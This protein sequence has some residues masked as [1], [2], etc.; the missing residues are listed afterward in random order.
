M[1]SNTDIKDVYNYVSVKEKILDHEM[2]TDEEKKREVSFRDKMSK[3]KAYC[4]DKEPVLVITTASI[5]LV[6]SMVCLGWFAAHHVLKR[7]G[8]WGEWTSWSTC[9]HNC[10]KYRFRGC[11]QPYPANGGKDC[12]GYSS[13][14]LACNLGKCRGTDTLTVSIL[15]I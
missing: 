10:R 4:K 11:V 3:I 8:G 14:D 13:E 15:V 2:I 1:C 6:A 12:V 7:D 5:L 9:E